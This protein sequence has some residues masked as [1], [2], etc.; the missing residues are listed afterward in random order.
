MQSSALYL[1]SWCSLKVQSYNDTKFKTYTNGFTLPKMQPMPL[2]VYLFV[3]VIEFNITFYIQK[4]AFYPTF[5]V[6]SFVTPANK[7]EILIHCNI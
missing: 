2:Y 5:E 7:S 3:Q 4:L 1:I 6:I